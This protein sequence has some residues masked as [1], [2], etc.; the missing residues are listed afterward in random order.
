MRPGKD[1]KEKDATYATTEQS[2]CSALSSFIFVVLYLD[3]NLKKA[4]PF[5]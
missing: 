2:H 3:T 1:V 4:S 5:L